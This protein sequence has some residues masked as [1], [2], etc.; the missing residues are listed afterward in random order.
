[1][2]F[3]SGPELSGTRAFRVVLP[4]KRPYQPAEKDL[5]LCQLAK[6]GVVDNARFTM[7]SSRIPVRAPSGGLTLAFGPET[8]V[9]KSI[10]NFILEDENKQPLLMIYKSSIGT[11]TLRLRE[12][13]TPVI[14]FGIA[15]ASL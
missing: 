4:K 13:I 14:A 9:V 15:I 2:R 5:E 3:Y 8:Y 11:C 1:M 12:P 10:K 6:S 7:Y